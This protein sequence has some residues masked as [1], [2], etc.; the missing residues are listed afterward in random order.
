M[1]MKRITISVFATILGLSFIALMTF[2][3]PDSWAA[4]L[5][6]KMTDNFPYPFTIQNIMWILF[7]LG[8][9]ELFYRFTEA[10]K[11]IK[12]LNEEYLPT[13]DYAVLQQK[14]LAPIFKHVKDSAKEEVA[15]L[16][17]LIHSAILQF[18]CSQS[19]DQAA[20]L[21]NSQLELFSHQLEL[22]YSM[23]RYIVWLIPTLGFI[24]TVYGI[25]L[26]LAEAGI[27]PPDDPQLLGILTSKLAVAFDTTLLALL[28][29]AILVYIMHIAQSQEESILNHSGQ[30]CLNDLINRLYVR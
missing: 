10:K 12:H 1:R 11:G 22:K 4:R 27:T 21:V 3:L 17:K 30:R 28:Q 24:G 8:I 5:L 18:Q 2:L 29:S 9:G 19:I 26:T 13:D 15:Y 23:L 14:D 6:D 7:F 25:S 20:M 16:P